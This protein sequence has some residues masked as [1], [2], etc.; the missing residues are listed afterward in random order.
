MIE[1]KPRGRI[2]IWGKDTTVQPDA[3]ELDTANTAGEVT[4]AKD[5]WK[6]VYPNMQF[7]LVMPGGS[8]QESRWK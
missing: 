7:Q 1:V 5:E 6:V 3:L 4:A 2:A 8:M